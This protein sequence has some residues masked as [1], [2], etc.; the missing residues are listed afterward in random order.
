MIDTHC[1]LTHAEFAGDADDAIARAIAAGVTACVTIGT[2]VDDGLR[3][4]E[5]ALRHAGVVFAT[6]GLDP[7]S[8][9]AAGAEF[10]DAFQSLVRLLEAVAVGCA[11]GC[12]AP[13]DPATHPAVG[14]RGELYQVL[15]RKNAHDLRGDV[16]KVEPGGTS[17]ADFFATRRRLRIHP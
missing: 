12:E 3:A 11:A 2:G 5:L 16:E 10:D 6:A 7:F 13:L 9:H 4:R 15:L 14:I 1:H 17:T 8:S